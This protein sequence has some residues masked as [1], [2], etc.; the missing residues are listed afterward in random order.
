MFL[1]LSNS[2][3]QPQAKEPYVGITNSLLK[4]MLTLSKTCNRYNGLTL[5]KIVSMKSRVKRKGISLLVL[6]HVFCN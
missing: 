6:N 4:K 3:E 2:K 5:H 1:N